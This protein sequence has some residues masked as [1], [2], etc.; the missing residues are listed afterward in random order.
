MHIHAYTCI[1]ML[2]A[3]RLLS[4]DKWANKDIGAIRFTLGLT[5]HVLCVCHAETFRD[6]SIMMVLFH[7]AEQL[8]AIRTQSLYRFVIFVQARGN[9]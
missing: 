7:T 1:Y 3:H 8:I 4:A 2:F 5:S 9:R 6:V